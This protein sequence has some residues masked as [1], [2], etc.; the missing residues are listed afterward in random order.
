MTRPA[1]TDLRRIV[2]VPIVFDVLGGTIVHSP[3][4]HATL[5]GVAA[6]LI[7]DTGSTDHVLTKELIDEVGLPTEPGEAGTDH[8]GAEVP[9]WSVGEAAVEIGGVSFDLHGIVAITGPPPFVGWGVGGFLSPQ[10]LHPTA[11][12]IIDLA[13][14]RLVLL[15]GPATALDD[16]LD[17]TY[18]GFH[19][20]TLPRVPAATTIDVNAAIEPHA[21]VATML[22]T[23]GK[24]T[25]FSTAVVPPLPETA[26]EQGGSG[27]SG[28]GVMGRRVGPR[29]LLVGGTDG[30]RIEV[31]DLVVR[32]GM[33]DPPGLVGEDV[34]RGTILVC[35]A[36]IERDVRWLLPSTGART[37]SGTPTP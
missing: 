34:L 12:V 15:D 22:N 21:P 13:G 33:G 11:W 2:D 32:D 16:W 9:S 14:D 3:M 27:L 4:V 37:G 24:G 35:A 20:L 1:G 7:L 36:D 17:A 28:A 23:G 10:H 18:A 31:G 5:G 29:T 25:E 6:R 19:R 26:E 8:A 30:A